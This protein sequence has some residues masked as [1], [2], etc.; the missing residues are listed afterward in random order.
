MSATGNKV[1]APKPEP[2]MLKATS[3]PKFCS[4]TICE[5]INTRNPAA[6]DNTFITIALPLI[7]M[8]SSIAPVKFLVSFIV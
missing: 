5:K 7:I 2:T 6:P 3:I 8:V 4:G 1:I